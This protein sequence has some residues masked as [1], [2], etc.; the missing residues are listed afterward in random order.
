MQRYDVRSILDFMY[1]WKY[2]TFKDG[3]CQYH[4]LGKVKF[5]QP[6]VT[7]SVNMIEHNRYC[8]FKFEDFIE[9]AEIG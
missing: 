8:N 6:S 1:N 3:C 4:I 5:R 9:E 2:D 7:S